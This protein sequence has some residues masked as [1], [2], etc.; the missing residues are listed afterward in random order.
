LHFQKNGCNQNIAAAIARYDPVFWL[1]AV[2]ILRDEKA[3]P[4]L[5][6]IR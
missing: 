2:A 1:E 6:E 3:R 5:R 4:D